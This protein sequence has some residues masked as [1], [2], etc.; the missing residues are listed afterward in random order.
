MIRTI[1]FRQTWAD[2]N[3][4]IYILCILA[5][6]ASS[7]MFMK[8][9]C[10]WIDEITQL[11]GLSLGP[12]QNLH[13]LLKANDYTPPISYWAGMLW[14][15]LFG[16]T[17]QSMRWFSLFLTTLSV[18]IICRTAN[19][20][21]G[22]LSGAA[23]GMSMAL[24]PNIVGMSVEIR[25]YPLFLLIASMGL[26][27]QERFLCLKD[28]R[29]QRKWLTWLCVCCWAAIYTHLYGIF[30]ALAIFTSSFIVMR[31]NQQN[32]TRLLKAGGILILSSVGLL[33][34]IAILSQKNPYKGNKVP[35]ITN[36]ER[37]IY[38]L[39]G[40]PVMS[41]NN[42]VLILA[43]SAAAMLLLATKKNFSKN[44]PSNV[45]VAWA[46]AL[47]IGI[48]TAISVSLFM[49]FDAAAPRYFIWMLPAFYL[50]LSSALTSSHH[51]TDKIALVAGLV[52]VLVNAY[53]TSQLIRY[54]SYFSH[55]PHQKMTQV[56][57]SLGPSNVAV[58][59]DSSPD[60]AMWFV[61]I[62]LEYSYGKQLEQYQF[63]EKKMEIKKI[64]GQPQPISIDSISQP[65]LLVVYSKE[66]RAHDISEYIKNG[67]RWNTGKILELKHWK[68]VDDHIWVSFVSA[69]VKVFERLQPFKNT[70]QK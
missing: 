66:S 55:G 5:S 24:S 44:D 33:A 22:T 47:G 65:K 48:F 43:F 16:N 26:Y 62:P 45:A 40:H 15:R 27:C 64:S 23:A 10:L 67:K 18:I 59:Y 2:V 46:L 58:L 54:G 21:H 69:E 25:S 8:Y 32:C 70:I 42:I 68:Q 3:R 14:S 19:N 13:W 36:I 63:D 50:L 12:I 28:E 17:E 34:Y 29:N 31:I 4:C 61:V 39:V 51:K 6:V 9:Q 7:A 52:F 38:R 53:S 57:N 30:F 49:G 20:S 1:P 41:L 37:L 11:K 60:N 56:I 35:Y